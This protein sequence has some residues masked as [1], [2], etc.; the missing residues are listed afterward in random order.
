VAPAGLSEASS[1]SPVIS[2]SEQVQSTVSILDESVRKMVKDGRRQDAM[3]ILKRKKIHVSLLDQTEAQ[4]LKLDQMARARFLP[5][6]SPSL[7]SDGSLALLIAV[8]SALWLLQVA[9]VESAVATAEVFKALCD[10]NAILSEMNRALSPE[11]AQ[12][13]LDEQEE[14]IGIARE[15]GSILGTSI[16]SEAEHEELE[17]DLAALEAAFDFDSRVQTQHT[18]TGEKR[19]RD[20]M[21]SAD[22]GTH[23]VTSTELTG[24]KEPTPAPHLGLAPSAHE[25]SRV[26][27]SAVHGCAAQPSKSSAKTKREAVPA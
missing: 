9:E 10:G 6:C 21:E 18:L 5:A 23:S 4:L 3:L 13:M 25:R 15:V 11:K 24:T 26:C 14:Q 7:F 12:E 19:P 27:A 22:K 8:K 20:P 17:A 1:Q 16:G 2:V